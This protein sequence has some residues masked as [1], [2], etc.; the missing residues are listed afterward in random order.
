ML[1]QAILCYFKQLYGKKQKTN[2]DLDCLKWEK[3]VDCKGLIDYILFVMKMLVA[4]H[5]V[6]STS[7]NYCYCV[8]NQAKLA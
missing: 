5:H 1:F 3:F 8:Y 4:H 6:A 2:L 7:V